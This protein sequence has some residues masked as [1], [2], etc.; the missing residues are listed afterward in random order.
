MENIIHTPMGGVHTGFSLLAML[1]GLFVLFTK[2]G[3]LRH[4]KV[5]YLYSVCMLGVCLTA[6]LLYNLTGKFGVFHVAS[7]VS[8]V[9][10]LG[11]MV[12]MILKRPK[13]GYV[14][15][16][17]WF[18]YYSVLGLY[19]AFFSE[20]LVRVPE[21]PFFGMVGIAT[22]ATMF[23]GSAYIYS[24]NKKWEQMFNKD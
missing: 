4:K 24:V 23:I 19:A 1:F 8:L 13:G 20:L 11:G 14:P 5:G 15:L 12:P 10:L 6:F 17:Y 2:K 21:T 3:T 16:H 18:M 7:I 22:G 9:T